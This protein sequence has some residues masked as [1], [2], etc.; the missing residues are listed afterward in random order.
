MKEVFSLHWVKQV[1]KISI[2]FSK[3]NILILVCDRI[4]KWRIIQVVILATVVPPKVIFPYAVREG[5][6]HAGLSLSIS[7]WHPSMIPW[8]APTL[9]SLEMNDDFA[10]RLLQARLSASSN[11]YCLKTNTL[12]KLTSVSKFIAHWESMLYGSD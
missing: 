4:K 5:S 3:Q 1:N 10:L 11:F 7:D 9:F 6:D 8:K 12:W 2:I